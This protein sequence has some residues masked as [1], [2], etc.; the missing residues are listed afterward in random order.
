MMSYIMKSSPGLYV[1][2]ELSF[3]MNVQIRKLRSPVA[4]TIDTVDTDIKL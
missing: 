4:A 2:G 3:L 1:V